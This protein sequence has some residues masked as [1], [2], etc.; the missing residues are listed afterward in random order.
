MLEYQKMEALAAKNK[1]DLEKIAETMEKVAASNIK[2]IDAVTK[3]VAALQE[4][5]KQERQKTAHALKALQDQVA[6]MQSSMER[7]EHAAAD[8]VVKEQI[9]YEQHKTAN[10]LKALS[11]QFQQSSIDQCTRD[12]EA[13]NFMKLMMGVVKQSSIEQHKQNDE[14]AN[15]LKSALTQ[16]D[17]DVADGMKAIR[18]QIQQSSIELQSLIQQVLISSQEHHEQQKTAND[19]KALSDKFQQ[20]SIDQC[21]RDTEAADFMKV[22]MDVVKQC[23]MEQHKQNTEAANMLKSVLTQTDKDVADGMKAIRD[24]IQQSS[25]EQQSLNKQVL[26]MSQEHHATKVLMDFMQH[27]N[28]EK[29]AENAKDMKQQM[30]RIEQTQIETAEQARLAQAE[31]F[32]QMEEAQDAKMQSTAENIIHRLLHEFCAINHCNASQA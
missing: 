13:A 23:S 7:I 11:D 5:D 16:T 3:H 20:S 28:Q 32:R 4:E 24:Q 22:L 19:L 25:I 10:D 9:R 1:H 27:A 26:I 18:D 30:Q 12:S 2:A 6:C 17:K 8:A 15:M 31:S 29:A 21:N 14:A